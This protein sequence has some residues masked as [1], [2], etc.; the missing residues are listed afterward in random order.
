M[1]K[2][3]LLFKLVVPYL[4]FGVFTVL[5]ISIVF[6]SAFKTALINRTLDQLTSINILKSIQVENYLHD[7]NNVKI[8]LNNSIFDQIVNSSANTKNKTVYSQKQFAES[9][10]QLMD[11]QHYRGII[12]FNNT[13]SLIF[14]SGKDIS[15]IYELI[16]KASKNRTLQAF[17]NTIHT[18][19]ALI[20]L[21]PFIQNKT[22]PILIGTPIYNAHG[23]REGVVILQK[24]NSFINSILHENTG[25]GNTG[26]SYIVGEDYTMRSYSRFFT[27]VYPASIQVKTAATSSVFSGTDGNAEITDYRGERVLSVFRK[28]KIKGINWAIISE[29]D[30]QEAMKP[31]YQIRNYIIWIG[32]LISCIIVVITIIISKNISTPVLDLHKVV[33][34]LSKG[35]LPR[36]KLEVTT[37]DEIG[38]ITE[39]L[40]GLVEALRETSHFADEIGKGNLNAR[41]KPLSK[42]DELGNALLQMQSDLKKL[43]EEKLHYMKQRSIALIEGQEKE[44][45]RIARELHDGIGQMLT[46]IRLKIN[47]I[48]KEQHAKDEL[49]K[50]LDD[51]TLEIKRISKNLMP[52]LLLDFGLKSALNELVE[53]TSKYTNIPIEYSYIEAEN[54]KQI[55][56]EIAVSIYRIVQEAINNCLKYANA[57]LIEV[58]IQV[59][60]KNIHLQINDNG[61]GFDLDHSDEKK[62][63]GIKNM[64]ERAQL[65]NGEFKITSEKGKGTQIT[66][67]IPNR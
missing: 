66:I 28:L 18:T 11:E 1:K 53:S 55:N 37:T 45:R 43:N 59:T 20:D 56:F 25:M 57:G 58:K 2:K 26:E 16:R 14:S 3:S 49:K 29:I 42:D 44:R 33:L 47:F 15:L 10:R 19:T 21:T 38:Q 36:H 60:E 23:I 41:F 27:S 54:S 64:Q 6:Y 51:T 67:V 35:V 62:F 5:I 12:V 46:A 22:M 17:L 48:E 9:I 31:I 40:N 50:M 4:S 39:A 32:L 34:S 13:D 61:A 52:N 65:F 24:K 8:V 30:M 7:Q 63:N